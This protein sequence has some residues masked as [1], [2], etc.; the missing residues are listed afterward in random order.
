MTTPQRHH[1][2]PPD[3]AEIAEDLPL[4]MADPTE[5]ARALQNLL[6]NAIK[7]G[8][9]RRWIGLQAQ[10]QTGPR[11]PEVYITV[12][13]TGMGISAEDLPYIFEPFYR[14]REAVA[15]Q[16]HG[17]GLGLSVVRQ[18]VEAHGG[19]IVVQSTPG[20]GSAF[21]IYLPCAVNDGRQ[22]IGGGAPVAARTRSWG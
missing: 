12:R 22:P 1:T 6:R 3:I 9:K 11:G 21:T 18:T 14:S 20:N 19:R 7:Y 13:D 17:S 2:T 16:I 8:G 10:A 15:A 4:L 5:M